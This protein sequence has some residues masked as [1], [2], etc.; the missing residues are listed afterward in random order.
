MI[1]GFKWMVLLGA[2]LLLAGCTSPRV[3]VLHSP[4]QPTNAQSVTYTATAT[5]SDGVTA[6]EIWED[7]NTLTTCNGMQCATN[8]STT[9]LTTCNISPAQVNANC[10]F[11]TAGGYPDSSFIA[12]SPR[13]RARAR[14]FAPA[15]RS[16]CA[17]GS[18]FA[19][20]PWRT[21]GRC[22]AV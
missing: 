1:S 3:F 2:T 18:F 22:N 11:T 9:Q 8:V 19:P 6:I 7:R 13:Y 5:D 21:D 17:P 15:T 4:M 14:S 16:V 20:F 12:S 10:T